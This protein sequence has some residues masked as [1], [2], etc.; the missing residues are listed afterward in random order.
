MR[1]SSK[2]LLGSLLRQRGTRTNNMFP[3]LLVPL[4]GGQACSFYG[5]RVGCVQGLGL[6]GGL[7]AVPTLLVILCAGCMLPTPNFSSR[8]FKSGSFFLFLCIFWIQ[9]LPQLNPSYFCPRTEPLVLYSSFVFYF[10]RRGVSRCKHCHSAAKCPRSQACLT[11]M[12][13]NRG[14]FKN[15]C[16]YIYIYTHTHILTQCCVNGCCIE[17]IQ[18]CTHTYIHFYVGICIYI[19]AA[20][21]L[22]S[23]ATLCDPIDGSPPGSPVP[24]ILQARTLEWV[25]ISFSSA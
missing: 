7:G 11:I 22:Q 18:F 25:A 17:V 13:H 4:L 8:L 20:K 19:Y 14:I 6:R 12:N 21:S 16:V 5:V 10:L 23:C 15:D 2:A 24:G 3:C 1:N 9:N